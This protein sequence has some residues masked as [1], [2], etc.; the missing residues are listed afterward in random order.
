M[1]NSK[2]PARFQAV[3]TVYRLCLSKF[4]VSTEAIC[5]LTRH[6]GTMLA[7]SVE[8]RGTDTVDFCIRVACDGDLLLPRPRGLGGSVMKKIVTSGLVLAPG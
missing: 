4:P 2:R 1:R 5:A 6:Q 3:S 8:G 7:I